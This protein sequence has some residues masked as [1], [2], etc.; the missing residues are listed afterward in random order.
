MAMTFPMSEDSFEGKRVDLT[1]SSFTDFDWMIDALLD[2]G[3]VIGIVRVLGS[4]TGGRMFSRYA[5]RI[6][7]RDVHRGNGSCCECRDEVP[8]ITIGRM[9][10]VPQSGPIVDI[11]RSMI[12]YRASG[13]FLRTVA[14]ILV[15]GGKEGWRSWSD[16]E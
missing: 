2:A 4:R 12:G 5:G 13:A 6:E 3:A 9:P 15:T 10:G 16:A 11:P 8:D 1:V 14:N 7:I